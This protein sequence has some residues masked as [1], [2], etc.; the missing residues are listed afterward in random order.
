M[1][2][3]R[4]D[5]SALRQPHSRLE[6]LRD[7][8]R[9][10]A[11]WRREGIPPTWL[12][13]A[14]WI[15]FLVAISWPGPD[16]T[17]L[18]PGPGLDSG[19][20]AA[21]DL[22]GLVDL[23]WGTDIVFSYGPLGFLTLPSDLS[24]GTLFLS[25]LYIGV[26]MA[27]F[28]TVVSWQLRRR[29][30]VVV[31]VVGSV[32]ILALTSRNMRLFDV[33]ALT[34]FLVGVSALTGEI[35]GRFARWLPAVFGAIAAV[36]LLVKVSTGLF[37]VFFAVVVAL[38]SARPLRY[39]AEQI[40]AFLATFVLAWIALGQPLQNAPLW[41]YRT[42]SVVSGYA[43]SMGT[44]DPSLHW[45]YF[46][47]IVL[48]VAVSLLA[49]FG[50]E[51]PPDRRT[52]PIALLA[53]GASWLFLKEA[54]TRHDLGHSPSFFVFVVL[55]VI[56]LPWRFT[57]RVP[58]MILFVLA[59][60][61][62]LEVT[63]R[64][65]SAWLDYH[66]SFAS[67]IQEVHAGVSTGERSASLANARS[68]IR[69]ALPISQDLIAQVGDRPV[70]ID[71][72]DTELAWANNLNWRPVPVFASYSAYTH[73]LDTANAK[74][75]VEPSGPTRVLRRPEP[76][77]DNRYR[78][79][80]NPEYVLRL[81]CN[82]TQ[83]GY[84]DSW[85]LLARGGN[86]CGQARELG[87]SPLR[88]GFPIRVPKATARNMLVVGRI[89]FDPS[90]TWRLLNLVLKPRTALLVLDRAKY[91]FLTGTSEGPLLLHLPASVGWSP[92]P[93]QIIDSRSIALENLSGSASISFYEIPV[94][95][96]A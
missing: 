70:H 96:G 91:R 71:A 19:W 4:R 93:G 88:N 18:P 9:R 12:G 58:A 35:K 44:D 64:S 16:S 62:F 23:N 94:R 28:F 7:L 61:V 29:Y 31:A 42:S 47:A 15:G 65:G 39:F 34:A 92:L 52:W 55:L 81:V 90:L 74:R 83:I 95:S 53:G 30:G 59:S 43:S 1:P 41:L 73:T 78:L 20:R 63:G 40:I 89:H 76:G 84:Q 75:L 45:E 51:L 25:I 56:A 8:R 60:S 32:L 22:A 14:L 11:V 24:A 6:T 13:W 79:Q 48:I 5:A 80:E 85:E 68:N 38:F 87:E 67:I 2:R 54:F 50:L 72:W 57:W 26:V 21:V 49:M 17:G 33:P 10:F 82:F 66:P 77:V 27:L 86:R 3:Q 36:E 46:A 69:A 37:I